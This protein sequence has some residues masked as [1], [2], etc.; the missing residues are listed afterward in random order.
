MIGLGRK[1][2]LAQG[3]SAAR[4]SPA[5]ARYLQPNP[6]KAEQ[7]ARDARL[8]A[9]LEASAAGVQIPTFPDMPFAADSVLQTGQWPVGLMPNYTCPA[10]FG[11][12]DAVLVAC[13]ASAA[14]YRIFP[15]SDQV[16]ALST[17]A[18]TSPLDVAHDAAR[19]RILVAS[20]DLDA[21]L[22]ILSASGRRVKTLALAR[23]IGQGLSQ[24]GAQG[25]TIDG[26]GNYWVALAYHGVPL[27]GVVVMVDA[28]ELKPRLILHDQGMNNP[29][30]IVTA[31]DGGSIIAMSDHGKAHRF[32]LAGELTHVYDTVLAGYRGAVIQNELWVCGWLPEGRMVRVNLNTGRR[33]EFD[34]VPLANSIAVD[35]NDLVWVAGDAGV[36]ISTRQGELLALE[37]VGASANGLSIVDG[38]AH[39][40]TYD[41]LLRAALHGARRNVLPVVRSDTHR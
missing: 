4:M 26:E 37:P 11:G 33:V 35:D 24:G 25:V 38:V 13:Y 1:P 23:E 16:D 22:I 34:C 14:V 17:G 7:V 10:R 36:S 9:W 2:A 27:G 39:F 30:G 29:N 18:G 32:S 40:V 3:E 5:L 20:A 28:A 6:A 21:H 19:H 8:L 31:P 12:S 41:S 15:G